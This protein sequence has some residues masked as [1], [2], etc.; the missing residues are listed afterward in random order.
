MSEDINHLNWGTKGAG[1][2]PTKLTPELKDKIVSYIRVGNYI[3]TA[4]QACG[5]AKRTFYHW[6][7]RANKEI[8]R[9]EDNPKARLRQSE[10]I[11]VDFL[12]AIEKAQAEAEAKD[13]MLL[14][15][16]AKT[17]SNVVRW[18]LER[19]HP[20]RWGNRQ[21]FDARVEHSGEVGLP[22]GIDE[23]MAKEFA[24]FLLKKQ[25]EEEDSE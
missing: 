3:E 1:G 24:E 16:F 5:I 9:L 25:L 20:Q 8:Q 21:Q 10:E 2:R 17:D 12:N 22:V 11:Y 6:L 23:K 4:V 15:Q 7:D 18:R 14:A 13:V 19:K